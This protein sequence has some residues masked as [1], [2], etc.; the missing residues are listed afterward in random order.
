M[1]CI[2]L[3]RLLQTFT[4]QLPASTGWTIRLNIAN[5][6]TVQSTYS[7]EAWYNQLLI[8]RAATVGYVTSAYLHAWSIS[9][10][11]TRIA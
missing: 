10:R 1:Q 6:H 8:N 4:V 9:A 2:S 3:I 5:G 11:D 7:T